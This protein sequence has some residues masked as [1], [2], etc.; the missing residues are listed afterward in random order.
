MP[1]K[2]EMVFEA[3]KGLELKPTPANVSIMDGVYSVLREI[4]QLAKGENGD[5]GTGTENG[6]AVDPDGRNND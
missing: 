4:Y 2:I 3:L 6:P 1:E 5:A